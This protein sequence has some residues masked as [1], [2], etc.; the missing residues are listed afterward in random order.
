MSGKTCR[1]V[2]AVDIGAESG[3]VIAVQY[4]GQ[5]LTLD[6]RYRFANV[7]V[8]VRGTL[9]WDILRLW[10]DVQTGIHAAS[11]SPI[12][13]IG[14]DTWAID[15]GLLDH[16]GNLIGNPVHYRDRRT[17]GVPERVFERVPR[18][19]V[20]L[21]TGIQI[22]PFNT[23]YQLASLVERRDPSLDGA[24]RL[25][26]MPDLLFYWLTGFPI[27]EFTNATTTQCFNTRRG[28]W[29]VEL[30]ERLAIPTRLFKPVTLPGSMLGGKTP[31]GIPVAVVPHHDTGSA[32]VGVPAAHTQFAYLSSGTWSL[33][34]LEVEH[35]IISEA[36]LALNVT[37][38]GGYGGTYRLLK[39]IMG[40]W[41]IQQSR[42]TWA[43]Q[44]HDLTYDQIAAQASASPPFVSLIDPD[45]AEFLV[46]GDIPSRICDFCRQTG[47][48]EPESIG[49]IA[50]CIFESLA[51]KYRHVLRQLTGLT[52]QTVEALHV[53]G[54]GSLNALLCQMTAD[55]TGI[56]V[57]A[58]PVEATALGNAL[59]QLIT[60]GELK[61]VAQGRALVRESFPPVIYTPNDCAAWDAVDERFRQLI[62]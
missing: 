4:D 42:Q 49:M 28:D 44:G 16:A 45:S 33:L 8:T 48:P 20:F 26:T 3:R 1:T 7:P 41:L 35:P 50:R 56:P 24:D 59:V 6:E 61:S 55:A 43:A 54:G 5:R 60:L 11:S 47:Q 2:L 9:H 21:Q 15:F 39:N 52:G 14:I 23:L 53:V 46:P 58:G 51:L 22:L 57:L 30:L 13:S 37:N 32:V 31:D 10:Y 62:R 19:E 17:D 38:E 29:A 36:A 25:L 18:S 12:D 34:G 40:L 27:N